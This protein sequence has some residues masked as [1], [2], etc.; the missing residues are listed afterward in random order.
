MTYDDFITYEM[1]IF[2]RYMGYS[3]GYSMGNYTIH[4]QRLLIY[5]DIWHNMGIF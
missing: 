5:V 2:H 1:V 4:D 3:M